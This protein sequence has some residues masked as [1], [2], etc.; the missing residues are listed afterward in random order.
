MRE[1]SLS[2]KR[3]K[4]LMMRR[5]NWPR[6]GMKIRRTG[7]PSKKPKKNKKIRRKRIKSLPKPEPSMESKNQRLN[8]NRSSPSNRRLRIH[9]SQ[10][11]NPRRKKS[12]RRKPRNPM[13]QTPLKDQIADPSLRES[14]TSWNISSTG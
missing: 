3:E 8:R 1:E 2:D 6:N 11:K 9:P 4:R 5:T 13:T 7:R 14:M 12:R 10:R